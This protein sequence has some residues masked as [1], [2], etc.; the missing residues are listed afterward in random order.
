MAPRRRLRVAPL[1]PRSFS[2]CARK[3]WRDGC[4][5]PQEGPWSDQSQSLG[6]G[7]KLSRA[8]PPHAV[9]RGGVAQSMLPLRKETRT[10]PASSIDSWA[11][12]RSWMYSRGPEPKETNM[13]DARYEL[14]NLIK[15]RCEASRTMPVSSGASLAVAGFTPVYDT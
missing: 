11:R 6:T 3:R 7:F 9:L 2:R 5:S 15:A 12:P 10:L 14:Q 4:C 8:A 1:H 13:L